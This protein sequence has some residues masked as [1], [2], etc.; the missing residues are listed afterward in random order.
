[1]HGGK[2][3]LQIKFLNQNGRIIFE[4]RENV[5]TSYVYVETNL[6]KKRT[7][8]RTPISVEAQVDSFLYYISD[9]GHYR[10]TAN[11]FGISRASISGIIGRLSYAVTT[12]VG[13]KLIRLPTNEGEV[14]ELLMDI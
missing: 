3:L 1:M 7:R 14:Q 12:F 11:A 9:E 10:K 8:L 13:P 2:T 6:E 4:C 5:F